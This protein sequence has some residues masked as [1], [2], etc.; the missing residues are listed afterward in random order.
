MRVCVE[1]QTAAGARDAAVI[2]LGYGGGRRRAELAGLSLDDVT[3]EGDDQIVVRVIGKRKKERLAYMD[4][5]GAEAIRD[6]LAIRGDD[7]GPLF[8]SGRKG[9]RVNRGHGMTAQAIR[10]VIDRRARQAGIEHLTPHDLRRSFVSDL[11]DAGVDIATVAAM[12]GHAQIETTRRYDRRGEQAKQRAARS[13][14][15]PYVRRAV[16]AF[17]EGRAKHE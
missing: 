8:W 16:L 2:A 10:D 11:L 14:H 13:L 3:D 6:W 4:N 17:S 7:P 9:G 1:D 12:A 15:V 5:G